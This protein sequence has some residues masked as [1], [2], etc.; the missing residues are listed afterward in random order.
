V[1]AAAWASAT[2]LA[3]LIAPPEQPPQVA[4]IDLGLL[5]VRFLG[6]PPRARTVAAA[7]ERPI[8]SGTA[9]GEIWYFNGTTWI[10]TTTGRQPRYPG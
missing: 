1:R 8:L 2:S 10:P 9:D 5:T 7:P 6:G 3:L 4:T